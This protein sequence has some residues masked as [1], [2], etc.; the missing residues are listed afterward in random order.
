MSTLPLAETITAKGTIIKTSLAYV[1][2]RHGTDAL[3]RV[4]AELDPATRSLVSGMILSSGH[5]PV[6]VVG[7]LL[8]TIDRVLGRGDLALCWE[9]GKFAGE[10]EVTM[11]HKAV[12]QLGKLEYFLKVA[13]VTWG[14]YYSG[15][16]IRVAETS[17]TGIRISLK[18]FN[19]SSKAVCFRTGGWMWRTAELCGKKNVGMR[20]NA[21]VLDGQPTCEWTAT[22]S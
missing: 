1:E 8:T 22:F 11:F 21:C 5:Y 3:K 10:Y 17:P 4:I 14:F 19:P 20:H 2:E 7:A 16:T 13:S 18:D 6:P 15:G 12:F 9:V